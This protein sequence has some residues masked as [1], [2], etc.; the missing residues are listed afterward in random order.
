M[1]RGRS[2]PSARP[3]H[4]SRARRRELG[5]DEDA[6]VNTTFVS[7]LASCQLHG[8]EPWAYLRDLFCLLQDWPVPRIAVPTLLITAVAARR[9]PL[10]DGWRRVKKRRLQRTDAISINADVIHTL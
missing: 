2:R 5:S 8:I 6:C 3:G 7:L 1:A 9:N 4:E 10:L